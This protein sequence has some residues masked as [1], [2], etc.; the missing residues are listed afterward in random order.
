MIKALPAQRPGKVVVVDFAANL[1]ARPDAAAM[2]PDGIHLSPDA[3]H[4][5]AADFFI[6]RLAAIWKQLLVRSSLPN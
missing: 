4:T 5:V 6:P 1:A 2:R 3:S